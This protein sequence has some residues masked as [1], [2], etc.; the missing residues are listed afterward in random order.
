MAEASE[1]CPLQI[2]QDMWIEL[3]IPPSQYKRSDYTQKE[4]LAFRFCSV[5]DLF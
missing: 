5:D 4:M 2:V 1:E 3:Q